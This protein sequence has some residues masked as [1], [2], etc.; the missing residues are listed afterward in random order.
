MPRAK[1][2]YI[3]HRIPVPATGQE[4]KPGGVGVSSRNSFSTLTHP[5]VTFLEK[6]LH[7]NLPGRQAQLKMAPEPV[8]EGPGRRLE[9]PDHANRSG[10]LVL[11]FPNEEGELELVLTL[12]SRNID[13]GGQLSFPGGRSE[14]GESPRETAL[15][16]AR[17]EVGVVEDAVRVIG[18]LSNL[19]IANSNNYVTPVVGYLEKRPQL[20]IDPSEVEEVFTVELSSLA[21]KKNLE[22]EQ[23]NLRE[24]TYR[25]PYWKVHRVPLWGATAMMLSEFIEL[26]REWREHGSVSGDGA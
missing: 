21:S 8:D 22:A 4:E 13:H 26:Y 24:Y 12:R 3:A 25:V 23:W 7:G 11:L 16:E 9:A 14:E 5:F 20:T 1:F 19:Y 2:S 18:S 6:R 15:R 17:E 10:V